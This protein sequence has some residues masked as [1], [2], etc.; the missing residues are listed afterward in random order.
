MRQLPPARAAATLPEFRNASYTAKPT[1]DPM[2]SNTL[3]SS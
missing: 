1:R 3:R 2:A